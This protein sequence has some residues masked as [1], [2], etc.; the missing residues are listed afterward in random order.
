MVALE[1]LLT[2]AE[3][4]TVEKE[5]AAA[6]KGA[7]ARTS[8]GPTRR[9]V[10]ELIERHLRFTGSTLALAIA[11]RLGSRAREVRQGVPARVPARADRDARARRPRRQAG[12]R[13]G[14]CSERRLT[15]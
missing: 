15:A 5:L 8:A 13:Q 4:A 1:P 10:R 9:I 11:R 7:A 2:E 14:S 6:G 12:R 3:Q